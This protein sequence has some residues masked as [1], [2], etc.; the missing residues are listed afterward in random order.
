M[1]GLPALLRVLDNVN[2]L[3]EVSRSQNCGGVT[4]GVGRL[5]RNLRSAILKYPSFSD[6]TCQYPCVSALPLARNDEASSSSEIIH[7]SGN[8]SIYIASSTSRTNCFSSRRR[9]PHRLSFRTFVCSIFLLCRLHI[10]SIVPFFGCRATQNVPCKVP[11]FGYVQV[12][13]T[14]S[15]QTSNYVSSTDP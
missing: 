15:F 10:V 4:P 13:H 5:S 12:R 8:A 1:H 9:Q 2:V 11:C 7:E 6:A 14:I 3:R